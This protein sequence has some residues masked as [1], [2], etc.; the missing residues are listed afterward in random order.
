[1]RHRIY[2]LLRPINR[3]TTTTITKAAVRIV[4][5]RAFGIL[6]SSCPCVGKTVSV[7]NKIVLKTLYIKECKIL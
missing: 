6:W 4:A 3:K 1:M 5:L 7:A 2:Y